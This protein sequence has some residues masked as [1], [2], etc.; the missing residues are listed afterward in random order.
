[1]IVVI[2]A[3]IEGLTAATLLAQAGAPVTVLEQRPTAGGLCARG[4]VGPG[5]PHHGLLDGF[6]IHPE[7]A[8]LAGVDHASPPDMWLAKRGADGIAMTPTGL[9][10]Q[11]EAVIRF[12]GTIDRFRFVLRNILHQAAPPASANP[13]LLPLLSNAARLRMLGRNDLL[14]LMRI[15]PMCADDWVSEFTTDPLLRAA[16]C[17][18]GLAGTWAGP[19]SPFS[20]GTLLLAKVYA[21]PRVCAADVVDGLVKAL[22]EAGGTLRYNACVDRI[23]VNGDGVQAVHLGDERLATSTV[24]SALDPHTT[25]LGLTDPVFVPPD[26]SRD[27][28]DIRS[29][30]TFAKVLLGLSAP[31]PWPGAAEPPTLVHVGDDVMDL[32]RAFDDVKYRR[33]PTRPWMTVHAHPAASGYVAAI[34]LHCV[35]HTLDNG[36][37][38]ASELLLASTLDVLEAYAPGTKALIQSHQV[39]TPNDITSRFGIRGGH[40]WHAELA[41]DQLWSMRPTAQLAQHITPISGLFLASR[42]THV[43]SVLGASGRLAAL[44]V[45]AS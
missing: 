5:F 37:A 31:I 8:K 42:G 18:P 38:D 15:V 10:D 3:G 33:L 21:E 40:P 43:G 27:V 1:M 28:A 6:P 12:R 23:E 41:I 45:R 16:L 22:A 35:P 2:G 7:I 24:I 17:A 39:V 14:E 26:L 13:A 25:L 11:L 19:R 44:K 4:E 34:T 29:R 30:G 36:W 20:A 9:G 32:E